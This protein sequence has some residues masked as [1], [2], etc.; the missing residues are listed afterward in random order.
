[1]IVDD[2]SYLLEN[3]MARCRTS[4]DLGHQSYRTTVPQMA[5]DLV[6]SR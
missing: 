1:M 3:R 2:V 6:V 5:V 4:A